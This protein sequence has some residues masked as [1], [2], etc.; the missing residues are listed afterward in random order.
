MS[1]RDVSLESTAE[2]WPELRGVCVAA[3][4]TCDCRSQ[5]HSTAP[6]RKWKKLPPPPTNHN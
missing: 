3:A 2:Q 1:K 5:N 6:S 4:G